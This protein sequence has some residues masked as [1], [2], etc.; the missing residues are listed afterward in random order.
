[1]HKTILI[2][3]A[4]DGIGRATAHKLSAPGHTVLLHGR[5][6]QKLD[7]VAASLSSSAG[8]VASYVAD[9][10]RF[11][12]VLDLAETISAEHDQLDVL[13][14]NA[15]V[16]GAPSNTTESGLDLRFMVNTIAPYVLTHRL[17]PRM[18]ADGRIINVSSAAQAP[19][20]LAA[21]AGQVRLS[22]G[23]AYAQSKLAITMW[24]RVLALQEGAPIVIAVNPGSL[25]G[26][27]MVKQAFG[28]DGHDIGIG[29][30]ILTRAALSDAFEGASG[31]YYDN[32]AGRFAPPHPDALDPEKSQQVVDRIEAILANHL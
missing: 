20:N 27:K 6:P 23:A 19:V 22:D 15:G 21:L 3:G 13:I 14:N 31:R 4:T 25:L 2:T 12:D 7:Q 10:S 8:R 32:D 9:L 28:I 16:Y 1:M 18:V 11:P 5:N 26:S 17:L 24:S 30:D 29:A